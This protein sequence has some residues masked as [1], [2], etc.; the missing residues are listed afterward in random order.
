MNLINKARNLLPNASE[1]AIMHAFS[2][3]GV[4]YLGGED[5]FV[6]NESG[7]YDLIETFAFSIDEI[8]PCLISDEYDK[9]DCYIITDGRLL[10]ETTDN[11]KYCIKMIYDKMN[12]EVA[13]IIIDDVET[14]MA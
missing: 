10:F 4:E 3:V 8:V 6:N 11:L 13:Q 5:V 7:I 9:N 2:I 14:Q 12:E 1:S